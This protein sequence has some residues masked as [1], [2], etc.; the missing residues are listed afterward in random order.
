M[1]DAPD[2]NVPPDRH[3][4]PAPFRE[5]ALPDGSDPVEKGLLRRVTRHAGTI[6][7]EVALE[8]LGEDLAERVVEQLRGAA[9]SL[10]G[11][12]HVRIRPVARPDATVELPAIDHVI[13][14]ASAKGG[15]GKTTVAVALAR[16]LDRLGL[17]VALFDA[18]IYGPNVPHL[19]DVEGPILQDDAG[20]PIPLD[21][22]GVE[23]L[24]P[25]LAAGEA[26]TARRGAIAYGAVENLLSQGAWSER[27]V[28][29]IDMP[30]GSDDVAGA[31]LEHVPL[32]GAVFVTTPFDA[33][34]ADTRRTIR[35]YR[36]QGVAP[37]AGVVNM[38]HLVCSC[39]GEANPL[40]DD[41]VGLD[42]PVIHELP[43][44]RTLQRDLD[45]PPTGIVDLAGTVEDYLADLRPSLPEGAVD[46]RGLPPGSQVRQLADDLAAASPGDRVV[47]VVEDPSVVTAD[48]PS[49]AGDLL[50][51]VDASPAATTG[52]LVEVRRS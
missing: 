24:S 6:T 43:F 13:A 45:D 19:L 33:S 49:A 35:L 30:A 14:V 11:A 37:I 2:L 48:L 42:V 27:D 9:Y 36:E 25:G 47:A 40:F 51:S 10:E 16:A 32:D 23:V 20:R 44:D 7:V 5:I 26:P 46:L 1:A 22:D 3:R 31:V 4:A 38:H 50:A 17:D 15:V 28:L 18:D 41:A 21:A 29:V 39:C 8:G 12:D 52:M 34:V